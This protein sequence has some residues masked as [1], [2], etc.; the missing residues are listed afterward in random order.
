MPRMNENKEWTEPSR[1]GD[2][3]RRYF[4]KGGTFSKV[5]CHLSLFSKSLSRTPKTRESKAEKP[6]CSLFLSTQNAQM[7][8]QDLP[9]Q[10]DE[11]HA[12]KDLGG[13]A[14]ARTKNGADLD[15][16]GR[17]GEGDTADQ[18]QRQR[19]VDGG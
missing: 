4:R 1:R 12:A 6:L 3:P 15:A 18:H 5:P 2:R 19:Q 11:Q 13:K 14:I 10:Q 9:A 8:Q 7:L 16:G 17:Q